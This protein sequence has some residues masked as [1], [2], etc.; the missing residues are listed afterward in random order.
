MSEEP[1]PT[2]PAV[3]KPCKMGCGFFGS[4][5]TGDCCS[6]CWSSIKENDDTSATTKKDGSG[7][8]SKKAPLEKAAKK[9]A[10]QTGI[11][12]NDSKE[13]TEL[14]ASSRERMADK[15][16]LSHEADP[17]AA[18]LPSP[19]KK[20]KKKS[21]YKSMMAGMQKGAA[22]DVEKDKEILKKVTGGGQF[23]KIDKI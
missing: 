16:P 3:T 18:D 1:E 12:E 19:A 6:K 13:L 22:R 15:A 20:K 9:V 23:Q 21:S 7:D 11:P 4:N 2:K 8:E 17:A 10:E 5:A 14:S